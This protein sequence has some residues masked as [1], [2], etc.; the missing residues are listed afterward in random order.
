MLVPGRGGGKDSGD[1]VVASEDAARLADEVVP[2]LES[3]LGVSWYLTGG[4]EVDRAAYELCR[5]RRASAGVRG[6]IEHGDEA[7]RLALA[8]ASPEAVAWIASRA[9]SFMDESGFPETIEP[10]LR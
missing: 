4:T 10:W 9:I 7:V 2:L 5:L 6:G 8:Q 3:A 1:F